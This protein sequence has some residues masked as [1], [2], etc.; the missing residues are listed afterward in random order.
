MASSPTVIGETVIVQVESQGDSF[1]AGIDTTNGATRWRIARPHEPSWT[2]PV[3][4]RSAARDLVLLQ[5]PSKLTAHDPSTGEQVWSYDAVC[6]GIPT[7]TAADGL[8]FVP[9]AG[10]TALEPKQNES[11]EVKW[12]AGGVQPATACPVVH[13]GRLYAINR[14]GVLTAANSSDGSVAWRVRLEG[15]FWGTPVLAGNRLY[16]INQEGLCQVVQIDSSG[17]SAEVIG[18]GDFKETVLSSAA[19][20]DGALYVRSDRHLWKVAAPK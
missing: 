19:A 10:V 7:A 18:R 16:C 20:A 17:N 13:D 3:A 8:I 2:S 4:Y 6:D 12:K 1:A 11:P 14:A 15:A 9:S 5:S